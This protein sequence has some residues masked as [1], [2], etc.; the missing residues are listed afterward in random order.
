M[1]NCPCQVGPLTYLLRG[2]E[3]DDMPGS[4][5]CHYIS[6]YVPLYQ[7]RINISFLYFMFAPYSFSSGVVLAFAG[8]YLFGEVSSS[9]IFQDTSDGVSV[10]GFAS[11]QVRWLLCFCAY[12]SV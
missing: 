11:Q 8:R 1:P 2:L 12:G 4:C 6:R 7:C 3:L 5:G 9:E 10:G